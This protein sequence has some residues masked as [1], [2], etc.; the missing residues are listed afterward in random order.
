MVN[1]RKGVKKQREGKDC[2][3]GSKYPARCWKDSEFSAK[4]I[5]FSHLCLMRRYPAKLLLF[6]EHVLLLGASALAVPVPAFGGQWEQASPKADVR[7]LQMRLAE[8][9]EK[10]NDL[11]DVDPARLKKDLLLGLFFRSDIPI[12]YGLGSSGA[13]CAAIY[14]RYCKEKTSDLAALKAMFAR[15]ESFFHGASSG[16]DPLTSFLNKPLLIKNIVDVSIAEMANWKDRQPVV[17]LL[18]TNLPRQTAPL[19]EWFLERSGEEVF[20]KKLN[21]ELLPAHETM[22][23]AWLNANSKLFWQN[24]RGVSRFQ[25]ENFEPMI[26]ATVKGFWQ[27]NLDNEDFTLKICGAG[28]GGFMLGFA[29]NREIAARLESEFRIVFPFE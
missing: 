12:G 9:A 2:S 8:F 3:E 17:F 5:S 4:A 22:V 10:L 18:D 28:G 19:V 25:F 24:L 23:E 29:K 26:P 7:G 11:P 16:I 27:K 1:F 14:D 13:L 6:G 21:A 15:M 20:A